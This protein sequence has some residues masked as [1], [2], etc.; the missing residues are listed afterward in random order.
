MKV[1]P[2][3]SIFYNEIIEEYT[4]LVPTVKQIKRTERVEKKTYEVELSQEQLD[5]I[6]AITGN[7]IGGGST[8]KLSDSIYEGLHEYCS[9][10]EYGDGSLSPYTLNKFN[11]YF[12]MNTSQWGNLITR[13]D[14]ST[15]EDDE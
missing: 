11:T 14:G 13:E 6:V 12:M 8:R 10:K 4:E 9:K 5:L 1:N 2:Y 15:E 7:I 3:T